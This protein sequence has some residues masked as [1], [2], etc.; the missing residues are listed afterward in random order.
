M[1]SLSNI[2][3][4]KRKTFNK[5]N[6]TSSGF[7]ALL[8]FYWFYCHLLSVSSLILL[9]KLN[10]AKFFLNLALLLDKGLFGYSRRLFKN[11]CLLEAT[12]KFEV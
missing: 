6:L 11:R 2:L 4:N 9:S 3:L 10:Y 8:E 12:L 1:F 5:K 7:F